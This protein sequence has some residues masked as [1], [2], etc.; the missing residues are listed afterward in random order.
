[1]NNELQ[2]ISERLRQAV[3]IQM[4]IREGKRLPSEE[5]V[6]ALRREVESAAVARSQSAAPTPVEPAARV[7]ATP[8]AP[9]ERAAPGPIVVAPA[10]DDSD[11]FDANAEHPWQ[12]HPSSSGSLGELHDN[13]AAC[14]RC[15]LGDTRT[16][17]VFGVG[18]PNAGVMFVGEA[19]GRDEDLQGE[20]FV[21][22]A[23][24]LLNKILEAIGF[25]REDVYIANI[26]KC[27]PPG[28]RN[29]EPSEIASCEP[30]LRRQIELIRPLILCTLGAFAAKTM[31][32]V[33]TGITKL[34]GQIHDYHGIPLVPTFHPAALLR[35][36]NWKRPTWEDV[37][38]LRREYDRLR[39]ASSASS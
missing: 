31:L 4:L 33:N 20:P 39:E 30:I 29:P 15:P 21:G 24:Q 9:E 22:R 11:L 18:N 23:G 3:E 36:P 28:N 38:M 6:I 25:T 10:R 34:R 35:N 5:T 37:Q 16:E 7:T 14:R 32:S 19:P 17:F 27:R 13:Y 2:E 26:L 12:R 8:S 1:V